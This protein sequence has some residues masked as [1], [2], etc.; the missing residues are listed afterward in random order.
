[1][2]FTRSSPTKATQ[3][4]YFAFDLA[5]G[6]K[7]KEVTIAAGQNLDGVD[8]RLGAKPAVLSFVVSDTETKS[9]L[10]SVDYELCQVQHP[11]WCLRA[12]AP[13]KTEFNAPA[14]EITIQVGA[15]GYKPV[16]YEEKAKTFVSLLPGE[17]RQISIALHRNH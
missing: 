1:M 15:N 8:I 9:V 17:R 3:T 2:V 12:G 11:D 7:L 5:P 13:G 14:T 4:Y 10:S 16:Q 6:Q